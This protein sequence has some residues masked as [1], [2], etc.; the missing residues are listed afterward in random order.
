MRLHH[1]RPGLSLWEGDATD[2]A[3][4]LEPGS[5]QTVVTSPPYWGLRDYGVEGQLGA[6]A[7]VRDYVAN[8]VVLLGE[9]REVLADDGVLWLNLGDTYN[10]Y[11]NN[12]KS[13]MSSLKQRGHTPD[14]GRR[15]LSTSMVPNKSLVG[16]PWRVAL[17]L[18]DDGWVLRSDVI[19]VKPN[20][21]PEPVRDRPTRSHEHIFMLTKGSRYY[22]DAATVAE[23]AVEAGRYVKPYAQGTKHASQSDEQRDRTQ[24]YAPSGG[25][26]VGAT[27]NRRDVWTVGTQPFSGAHFAT[28]PPKLIEPCIL[29]SSR[30]ADLVLD[31][32]SGSGT[33]GMV[34]LEHGRRYVGV[35]MNAEY[36]DISLATRFKEG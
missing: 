4:H 11:N 24:R 33:T 18:V 35:D 14:P 29:S 23:P 12:R 7:D 1:E 21:M 28:F 22:Y 19:W 6:E 20:P 30:P 32:F 34:A 27:R 31:P 3:A 10:A 26:L 17:A 5:V 2:M 13:G 25:V 15:G 36:L 9:V 8:L 16:V